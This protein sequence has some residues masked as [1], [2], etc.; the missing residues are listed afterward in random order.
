MQRV[1]NWMR[2]KEKETIK[3]FMEFFLFCFHWN[4]KNDFIFAIGCL[5]SFSSNL[6]ECALWRITYTHYELICGSVWRKS[7]IHTCSWIW[8]HPDVILSNIAVDNLIWNVLVLFWHDNMSRIYLDEAIFS[9]KKTV[10]LFANC[11][12]QWTT[13]Y[14]VRHSCCSKKNSAPPINLIFYHIDKKIGRILWN[15]C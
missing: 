11:P 3:W 2:K 1:R 4:K 15:I 8:N 13:C 12:K 9:L 7:W 6:S 5:L 14:F 10:Q